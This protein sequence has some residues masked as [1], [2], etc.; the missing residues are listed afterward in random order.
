MI[1]ETKQKKKQPALESTLPGPSF[2]D[3][4]SHIAY[5]LYIC[6]FHWPLLCKRTVHCSLVYSVSEC[7]RLLYKQINIIC[8]HAHAHAHITIKPKRTK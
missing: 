8:N 4:H 3:E 7:W 2:T 1:H 5:M 6:T